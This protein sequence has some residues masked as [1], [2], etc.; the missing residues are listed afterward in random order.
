MHD[1]GN[2]QAYAGYCN[3]KQRLLDLGLKIYE[4]KFNPTVAQSL[5]DRYET[6][7]KSAPIFALHAKSVVVDGKVKS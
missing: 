4:F 2:L 6:R 1:T 7:E 3:Q 5:T